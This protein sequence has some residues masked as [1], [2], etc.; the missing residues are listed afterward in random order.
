[1][2]RILTVDDMRWCDGAAI[3][4]GTPSRVLMKRAAEAV[5][6]VAKDK[7]DPTHTCVVCGLGNNGGDGIIAAMLLHEAGYDCK[8][9]LVGTGAKSLETQRR[10]TEAREM[11][12]AFSEELDLSGATLIID[13]LL[14]IGANREPKGKLKDAIVKINAHGAAVLSVDIPSGVSADS[15][16]CFGEAVFAD[17]TVTMAAYKR[18]LF[19]GEGI[20][21]SGRIYAVDIGIDTSVSGESEIYA[22]EECEL[23]LIPKRPRR[24]NKGDFGR[25]LVIAGSD[26]MC[27]AAYLSAKAAYRSGAGLVE[28]FT[29][30]AN[31]T[32]LQTLLPEA[33]VTSYSC[34]SDMEELLKKSLGKATVVVIG[35]GLS[36]CGAARI[37]VK[38]TYEWCTAPIIIDADALNITALDGVSYPTDVPVIITPHPGEMARLTDKTTGDV[39]AHMWECAES[40]AADNDIICVLKG[41]RT[42]IAD[43]TTKTM[44]INPTGTPAL[45]KGGSGDVLTGVIAGMLCQGLSPVGAASLG[46]YIHG[47]AGERACEKYG[48]YS[49]LAGEVCDMLPEVLRHIH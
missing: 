28:I 15:G 12:I 41:A 13:A 37:A 1:M 35:P 24:A 3:N 34:V 22:L 18:G 4:G 10:I 7:F 44:F 20:E 9:H 38:K 27:G 49:P 31:R 17:A 8:I 26:G 36:T 2:K 45:S 11:G 33:I 21:H 5:A 23:S 43:G 40:Y 47:A 16:E 46:V 19:M 29:P 42:V 32:V 39:V 14:G 6:N 30:E 48:E 25:V